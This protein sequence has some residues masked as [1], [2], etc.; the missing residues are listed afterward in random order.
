MTRKDGE[1]DN[2]GQI[3]RYLHGCYWVESCALN[4]TAESCALY[5]VAPHK[6]LPN[7]TG[8]YK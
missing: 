7:T 6:S 1:H 4:R 5:P 8:S 2:S 3:G